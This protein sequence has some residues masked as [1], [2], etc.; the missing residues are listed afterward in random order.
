MRGARQYWKRTGLLAT[1]LAPG[2]SSTS[3]NRLLQAMSMGWS[4]PCK[5]AMLSRSE[6]EIGK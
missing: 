4:G 2:G 3:A 1:E 5:Y 6:R